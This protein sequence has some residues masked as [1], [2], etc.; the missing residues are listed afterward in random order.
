M[1]RKKEKRQKQILHMLAEGKKKDVAALSEL[2]NISQVTI[3]KDLDELEA[4]GFVRRSFGYAELNDSDDISARLAVHYD[5][6]RRIAA[7]AAELV[8]DGDT[9]MIESGSCCILLADVI[10]A[11]GRS[12]TIITNSAF[13]AEYI[14]QYRNVQVVL[15]GGMYQHDSRCLVG[16]LVK[17]VSAGYHVTYFFIGTDGWSE[18]TGFTNKD[19]MRAQAV[20]DMAEACEKMVILTESQKFSVVGTVPLN[21]PG[22]PYAVITDAAISAEAEG[23]LKRKNIEVITV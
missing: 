1:S 13:L 2:L 20:R 7:R 10:A 21:I 5:E 12:V 6:K 22:Q 23:L 11:S 16:P 9:I 4:K 8:Q 17:A 18:K 3:R 14:R 19:Q 15:C